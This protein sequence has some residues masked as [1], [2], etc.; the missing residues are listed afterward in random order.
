MNFSSEKIISPII[1]STEYKKI[2]PTCTFVGSIEPFYDET[3][4][5][6]KNLRDSGVITHFRVFEGCFHAFNTICPKTNIAKEANAFLMETFEY[7]AAHYF[8]K[9]P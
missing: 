4:E 8:A 9:Q 1:V 3:E 5:Y 6:V 7:A 2:P